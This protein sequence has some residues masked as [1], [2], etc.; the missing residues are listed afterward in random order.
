[1]LQLEELRLLWQSLQ[2]QLLTL[3]HVQGLH[4]LVI[5]QVIILEQGIEQDLL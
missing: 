5:N 4:Q 1:M 2:P 3:H